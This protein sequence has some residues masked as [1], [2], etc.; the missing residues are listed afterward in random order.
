MYSYLQYSIFPYRGP[1]SPSLLP[2]FEG[3]SCVYLQEVVSQ[4]SLGEMK[5][6][7]FKKRCIFKLHFWVQIR[8]CT[9]GYNE[10]D[11]FRKL[12]TQTLR[13]VQNLN[14]RHIYFIRFFDFLRVWLQNVFLCCISEFI[15]GVALPLRNLGTGSVCHLWGICHT[16]VSLLPACA[17]QKAALLVV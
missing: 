3:G 2:S 14:P 17:R 16:W 8:L 4:M 6:T 15:F 12:G 11:F 13:W 1:M 5:T 10:F 7:S 9:I